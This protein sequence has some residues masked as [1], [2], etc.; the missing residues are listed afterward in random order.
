MFKFF[1]YHV[2]MRYLVVA[3]D[4]MGMSLTSCHSTGLVRSDN[5][6]L[7]VISRSSNTNTDTRVIGHM[8]NA[9]SGYKLLTPHIKSMIRNCVVRCLVWLHINL[10]QWL[11]NVLDPQRIIKEVPT[12]LY[13]K[14]I[15]TMERATKKTMCTSNVPPSQMD[16]NTEI[17]CS[18]GVDPQTLRLPGSLEIIWR[19]Q[20][21]LRSNISMNL[22][23]IFLSETTCLWTTLARRLNSY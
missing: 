15:L 22:L 12:A 21:Y 18:D 13:G 16:F 6:L 14:I 1:K 11:M 5:K 3:L 20:Y 8:P 9:M 7:V 4:K 23:S 10:D 19:A 17:I 2:T